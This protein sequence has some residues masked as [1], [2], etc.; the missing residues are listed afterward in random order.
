[1]RLVPPLNALLKLTGT[2]APFTETSLQIPTGDFGSVEAQLARSESNTSFLIA[3]LNS[4]RFVFLFTL[5]ETR[6]PRL[7]VERGGDRVERHLR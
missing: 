7:D 5:N 1:M 4:P 2:A 6:S 3:M